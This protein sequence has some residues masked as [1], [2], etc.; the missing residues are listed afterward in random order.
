MKEGYLTW[1][2]S[3]E[4]PDIRY[5]DDTRYGGLHCGNTLEVFNRNK[6]Q[7]AR[8][9]Y[10]HGTDTWYLTGLENGDEILW[11]PVRH[12]PVTYVD[13]KMKQDMEVSK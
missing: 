7:S 13:I 1:N 8:I 11:L 6:W 9:E 5:R 10:C 12:Y 3:A 4:R 2:A